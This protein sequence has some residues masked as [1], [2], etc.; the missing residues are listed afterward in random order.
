[1]TD[2][3]LMSVTTVALVHELARRGAFRRVIV[4]ESAGVTREL[5][6]DLTDEQTMNE[7]RGF[8]VPCYQALVSTSPLFLPT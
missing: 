8:N 5:V 4:R 2:D 7:A 6:A 1:M 3:E